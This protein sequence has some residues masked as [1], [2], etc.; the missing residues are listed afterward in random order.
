LA[1]GG[2]LTQVGVGIDVYL[3]LSSGFLQFSPSSCSF[4][5]VGIP[6]SVQP[7]YW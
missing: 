7:R 5:C 3:H 6:S 4:S 1:C 2:I